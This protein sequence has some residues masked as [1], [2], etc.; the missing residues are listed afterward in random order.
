MALAMAHQELKLRSLLHSMPDIEQTILLDVAE[1]LARGNRE[2]GP[3]PMADDEARDMGVEAYQ[4]IRD[5]LI[6]LTRLILMLN[7]A[8][9]KPCPHC[10]IGGDDD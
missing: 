4:E 9:K 7:E 2:Y 6:Y 8:D 1:G 3:F 5:L 10:G